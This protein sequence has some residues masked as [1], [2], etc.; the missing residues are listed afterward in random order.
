VAQGLR[1]NPRRQPDFPLRNISLALRQ[2]TRQ[3]VSARSGGGR[4]SES[5]F[6]DDS[7]R[8]QGAG[9]VQ[10]P[11]MRITRD[12]FHARLACP[13]QS[14]R[15]TRQTTYRNHSISTTQSRNG[16]W[17]AA[18]GRLDGEMMEIESGKCA[19]CETSPHD[20]ETLAIAD[21]QIQIDDRVSESF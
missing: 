18:F 9:S 19:V 1:R 5:N 6:Q 11:G 20:V 10:A 13:S 4:L 7:S 8:P 15:G 21:A 3:A 12:V 2:L 17:V 14:I 16:M